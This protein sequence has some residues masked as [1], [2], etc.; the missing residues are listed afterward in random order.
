MA[1]V[2]ATMAVVVAVVAV[3]VDAEQNVPLDGQADRE[4][5]QQTQ[6]PTISDSVQK[7]ASGLHYYG[8]RNPE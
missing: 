3:E 4:G 2:M 1:M 8:I 6:H 5:R 7:R